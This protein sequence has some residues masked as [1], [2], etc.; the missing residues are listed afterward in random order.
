MNEHQTAYAIARRLDQSAENIEEPIAAKLGKARAQAL[1]AM[2]TPRQQTAPTQ[3]TPRFQPDRPTFWMRSAMAIVPLA[4]LIAGL[5]GLAQWNEDAL[6]ARIGVIGC[7]IDWHRRIRTCCLTFEKI[8]KDRV[9][10]FDDP[11]AGDHCGQRL[12]CRG[13]MTDC[14][15]HVIRCQRVGHVDQH[16]AVER[17]LH[18]FFGQ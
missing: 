17:I 9:E 11:R 16:L 2:S 5:V 7:N 10:R 4:V 1:Q 3:A 8:G 14:Q 18:A 12:T 15:A 13:I 6:R